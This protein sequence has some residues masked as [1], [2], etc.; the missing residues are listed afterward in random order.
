MKHGKLDALIGQA[1]Q[2]R[3][4]PALIT[5]SSSQKE[6]RYEETLQ[7]LQMLSSLTINC[8]VTKIVMIPGS[9]LSVL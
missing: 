7:E 5:A 8:Q 2:Y 3:Q 9:Q 1:V 6:E 4:I